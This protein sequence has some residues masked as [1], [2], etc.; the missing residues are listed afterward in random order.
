MQIL[1]DE[2]RKKPT[3]KDLKELRLQVHK[4][5]GSAGLYGYN[6]VSQICKEF[7]QLLVQ[8]TEHLI[9]QKDISQLAFNAI[10]K[11]LEKAFQDLM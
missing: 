2:I 6:E 10:W 11:K 3:E 5:A 8:E 9:L 7:D 1:I 4:L